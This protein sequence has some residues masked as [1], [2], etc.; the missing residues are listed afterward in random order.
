MVA[1]R[2]EEIGKSGMAKAIRANL[3]GQLSLM[4]IDHE[5]FKDDIALF[6]V[7]IVRCYQWSNMNINPKQALA[8]QLSNDYNMHCRNTHLC[9]WLSDSPTDHK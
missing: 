1:V 8:V 3:A 6:M 4:F 5:P 2:I 7:M 9:L